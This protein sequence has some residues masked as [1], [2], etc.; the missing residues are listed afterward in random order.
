MPVRVLVGQGREDGGRGAGVSPLRE[1]WWR[2]G[3]RRW[4]L[5]QGSPPCGRNGGAGAGGGGGGEVSFCVVSGTAACWEAV[6]S[7]R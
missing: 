5:G 7:R 6:G 4:G 1:K 3:W 2:R